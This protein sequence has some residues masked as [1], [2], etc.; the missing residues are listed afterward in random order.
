MKLH[1]AIKQQFYY[2]YV[3]GE[4]DD[5]PLHGFLGFYDD[6]TGKTFIYTHQHFNILYHPMKTRDGNS[7]G[8]LIYANV[9]SSPSRAR[10]VS[11]DLLDKVVEFTYSVQWHETD[12]DPNKRAYL[13]D[14]FFAWSQTGGKVHWL[15]IVNSLLL[16]LLLA[17]F[18][19]LVLF[20][21]LRKD[22][23][24]YE[25]TL[26]KDAED[27]L[28]A[29]LEY[30]WKLIHGDVFRFP[31]YRSFFCAFLG[32]GSQFLAISACM[33]FLALSGLYFPG[34]EGAIDVS[35][36]VLY[37]LTAI[38]AGERSTYFYT[39]MGGKAW[40]WNV[41]LT[42][43][44]FALPFF[45]IMILLNIMS[46]ARDLVTAMH[47]DTMLSVLAIWLFVGLPLTLIGGITGKR[48]AEASAF[49]APVRTKNF[50]REIPP[51]QRF[52]NHLPV[53]ML[54]GGLLPFGAIYLELHYVFDA[55]WGHAMYQLWGILA[56]VFVLLLLV[57]ALTSVALI[58]FQLSAENW[59]WWWSSF[60]IGGS[61]GIYI[62]AFAIHW[63]YRTSAMFGWMQWFFYFAEMLVVSYFFFIMLGTLAFFACLTFI[64][65]IY[66]SLRIE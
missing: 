13:N 9:T 17:G 42:A 39:H 2:E 1:K 41:V 10:E 35:A 55:A 46:V 7:Y 62:F 63:W 22:L 34:N 47:W 3:L 18:L 8:A 50:I 11:L 15:S 6:T 36:I 59:K 57:T 33:L 53:Q 26:A 49:S 27:P 45:G 52:W 23:A 29:E 31:N 65:A 66:S 44:L 48:R 43:T 30:G 51:V 64:R 61:T 58:F 20:R 21:I 38:I 4:L 16:V 25:A 60:I 19:A 5:V 32:V 37:A 12:T 14:G 56:I 54:I 28:D 24:R 40:S